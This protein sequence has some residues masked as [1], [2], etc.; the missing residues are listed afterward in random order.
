MDV[1]QAADHVI[2][3]GPGSGANGGTIVFAGRFDQLLDQHDSATARF[4]RET[5]APGQ[6]E[7]TTA[8]P[9][10]GAGASTGT[11]S[12]SLPGSVSL[13]GCRHHNLQSI[14][15]EFPLGCLCVVTGVSGSGKTS[16]V[17]QTLYPAL[18]RHI[19]TGSAPTSSTRESSAATS[20]CGEFDEL[21]VT[22]NLSGVELIDDRPLIASRRSSPVTWLKILTEIRSLFAD[23]PDARNRNLT[24]AHFSFNTDAGGRCPKC[25][26][27][28]FIEIDMQ[29][30]PDVSMTCPDCHGT[31][32]LPHIREVTWRNR[33]IADVLAMTADEAFAF[34]RGERRI[35]KKLVALRDVGLGYL[36]L[37]QPLSTLS[38]GEAQRLKLAGHLAATRGAANLL[39]LN[40]P[41]TGLHPTDVQTLLD[42]LRRLLTA[43]HSLIVIEHHRDV[44][45]AADH[46]ID[47]GPAAGPDGGR[48][49]ARGTP[50]EIQQSP[51]S[52]TGSRLQHPHKTR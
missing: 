26:G 40:E 24:A 46:V 48:I 9:S 43:G 35:Q 29:F 2:E 28:G 1:A 38:G 44:I 11:G 39:I 12:V 16:L 20:V 52:V 18:R 5:V 21:L 49:V 45:L 13:S 7:G 34:F 8:S 17:E 37:G 32:F 15:V 22:G 51:K 33:S 6:N 41:A 19:E 50:N 25:S 10:T 3:I 36:P 14:S 23:T 42:C 4:F 47:L 30:M 27:T 31:R